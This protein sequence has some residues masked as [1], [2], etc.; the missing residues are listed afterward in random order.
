MPELTIRH[1]HLPDAGAV[2]H[3]IERTTELDTNSRYMYALWCT[4]FAHHSA[5]AHEDGALVGVLLGYRKPDQPK[6]YFAWQTAV[7]TTATTSDIAAPLYDYVVNALGD[8]DT[9]EMSIDDSNRSV[10][11]L[12]AKLKRR[13]RA[14]VVTDLMFTAAD[15]GEGHHPETRKTLIL[16]P[17][18]AAAGGA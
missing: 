11:F 14:T 10:K 1:P 8:L 16:P 3:L 13:Y 7:S 4:D 6:T 12:L 5:V 2:H 18:T 15:L 17:R 9:I